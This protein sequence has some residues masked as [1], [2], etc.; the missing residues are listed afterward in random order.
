MQR[1]LA[2]GTLVLTM[3][4]LAALVAFFTVNIPATSAAPL[5]QE[6]ETPTTEAEEEATEE[7]TEEPTEEVTEEVTEEAT[8]AATEEPTEAATEE[9]TEVATA[10]ATAAPSPT[11]S[12]PQQL[13]TTAEGDERSPVSLAIIALILMAVAGVM[14][15]RTRTEQR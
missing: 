15:W 5:L 9:P 2:A 10:A 6:T 7:V 13:P 11:S 12:T 14:I 1:I 8:E 3:V 4:V